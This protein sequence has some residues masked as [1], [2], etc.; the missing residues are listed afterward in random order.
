MKEGRVLRLGGG[1]W[2]IFVVGVAL[3]MGAFASGAGGV[4]AGAVEPAANGLR[5]ALAL[6][7]PVL[8]PAAAK[9]GNTY[10]K[11][12]LEGCGN[13]NE[14]GRPALPIVS[15]TVEIPWNAEVKVTAR[16]TKITE[17]SVEHWVYP[18]QPPVP[19]VL[20]PAGNPP[21]MIDRNSYAGAK[22]AGFQKAFGDGKLVVTPFKKRGRQFVNVLVRPFAYDAARGRLQCPGQLDLDVAWT[23]NP[24]TGGEPQAKEGG[25]GIIV[26]ANA[27]MG[28]AAAA[29]HAQKEAEG[30]VVYD[31]TVSGTPT[32]ESVRNQIRVVYVANKP[33]YVVILGDVEIVPTFYS[34][35]SKAS[36][37]LLYALMDAEEGYADYLGKDMQVGRVSVDTSSA[38]TEYISKLAAFVSSVKH[39]DLTWISGG[40]STTENDT[41]EGTH[42]WVI[43]NALP[44]EYTNELFYDFS[45][46]AEEFNA[47]VNAGTDGVV[48]SGHGGEYLWTRWGYGISDMAGLENSLDAPIVFGHCCLAGS[49]DLGTCFAEAWIETT[50]RGI[51]YIGASNETY[52]AEDDVLE[53]Q[54]FQ[55]MA[56]I[57]ECRISDAVELGLEQVHAQYPSRAEYYFTI[58]QCFGDPTVS[59]FGEGELA[60]ITPSVLPLAYVGEPYTVTINAAGGE[61][62]YAWSL[63]SGTLPEGLSFDTDT[64]RISG[65]P[66]AP[67]AA[68]FTIQVADAVAATATREF[69]LPV[70]TRFQISSPATLP[71]APLDAAYNY[72]LE[73]EG[74]TEPVT[75]SVGAGDYAETNVASGWVGGGTAKGWRADDASWTLTLPWPFPFYGVEYTSVHVCSNGYLDFESN[76]YA[77]QNS[78]P[79]LLSNVRI[80]PLWD[81]LVTNGVGGDIFV[82][83]TTGYMVIRWAAETW[84]YGTPVNMEAVL[85]ADGGI[86]FNYGPAHSN[87]TPTIGISA[88]DNTH[89][90]LSA[91]DGAATIPASVSSLFSYADT[92]PA[93]ISLSE[94]GVLSGTA[95]VTGSYTFLIMATD[96]GAPQQSAEQ[97]FTLTFYTRG[98]I[99][100]NINGFIEVDSL[101]VLT[102]PEGTDYHWFWKGG[103]ELVGE[104]SRTLTFDPVMMDDRGTYVCMYTDG[105]GKTVI[106]TE[107]FELE[108]YEE[109]P[110]AGTACLAI[111][112]ACLCL[113]GVALVSRR[114]YTQ[115]S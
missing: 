34:T 41:A 16:E 81:D 104:N 38:V 24:T 71:A 54:E 23:L 65:T 78:V 94:A 92:L 52:W 40:N 108:V 44:E 27:S 107:P 15:Y 46:T 45:G 72:E 28:A 67:V 91:R 37:D 83:E 101:V 36:S 60:I 43:A 63:L 59:L 79:D 106:E 25:T 9:D 87:L 115:T 57:P 109:L 85:Y 18:H 64:H 22:S 6:D 2:A 31:V 58:Y 53:R 19:K 50:A 111:T 113:V 4:H 99:S 30:F 55:A 84:W 80:A 21:F 14:L 75:W 48:Y 42:N 73:T 39:R 5:V 70:V 32:A 62:P 82:T 66:T 95:T 8:E 100:C 102:A 74:G 26:V 98:R 47:H 76:E 51:V 1:F 86:R 11:V 20:G 105:D 68:T 17:V 3:G 110:A 7:A 89:F 97:E 88:G 77:F 112:V 96:S 114:R 93:G 33:E 12:V 35:T 49:F 10:T 13:D 103:E 61:E 90:T 56:D 69:S 29:Y